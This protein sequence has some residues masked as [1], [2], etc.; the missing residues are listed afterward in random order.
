MSGQINS[1]ALPGF[2]SELGNSLAQ[3][4]TA[5]GAKVL[6]IGNLRSYGD[7]ALNPDGHYVQ[8]TRCDRI[9]H[10]DR[11]ND[12][13]TTECG[14]TLGAIQRRLAHLGYMLP[15]TPGTACST[16]GGAIANDVHG[17][18]HHTAGTF[19]S[20][21]ERFELVRSSGETLIC[22]STENPQW[23]AATVG[24]MGLT[25]AITW[26]TMQLR[27]TTSPLLNVTSCRFDNLS[28]FFDLD[29]ENSGNHEY[30]VAWVDCLA[31]GKSL[32]KGIYSCADHDSSPASP[33]QS[34]WPD[35]TGVFGIPCALPLSPIKR[36]TLSAFN[37]MYFRTYRI[38]QR[39]MHYKRWL[40]PLDSIRDWNRLYG[41]R[42]F[43]QFQCVVPS[44]SA[45][46][47]IS[48]MLKIIAMSGQG[49][50]LAVLKNFGA[51]LSPGL[52]SF[53]MPGTTLAL[54]FANSGSKTR[55][56]LLKLY[57]TA[58]SAGGR[59]YHA[60]DGCSPEDRLLQGYPNLE[61]FRAFIDPGIASQLAQRLQLII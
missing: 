35:S 33:S 18:N 31:T 57:D 50:F 58:V 59:I 8:T 44:A 13:I 15:V 42:G 54:D 45:R 6:V 49:S 12:S 56:L 4:R 11:D 28:E 29:A 10:L 23:F 21:V 3:T 51:K 27:R 20:F 40:Y 52:M 9:I 32:G 36:L 25:G 37:Q 41:K 19:G 53:P 38:G 5:T 1:L 47:S 7:E 2:S 24:G 55:E 26:A 48:E 14:I 46:A 60:K 43:Y 61:R 30:T 22:S 17:K 34:K 39:Q 16:V